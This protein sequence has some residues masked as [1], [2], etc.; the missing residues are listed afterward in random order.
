MEI[1]IEQT[2]EKKR[3]DGER[4]DEVDTPNQDRRY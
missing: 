1:V 4:G 3:Y 2:R